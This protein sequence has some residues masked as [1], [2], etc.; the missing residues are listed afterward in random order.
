[1][2][3]HGKK[4]TNGIPRSNLGK[5]GIAMS[6]QD[7]DVVYAAIETD[8]TKG[9]IYRSEDR[10]ESWKKMSNTVSGGTGPHYY[11]NCIQVLINSIDCI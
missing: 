10:G 2:E 7:P 6:Y 11:Q 5:I 3:K 9:G 1:M 4:L 8:R